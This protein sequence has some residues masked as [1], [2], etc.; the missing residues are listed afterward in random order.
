MTSDKIKK[1]REQIGAAMS[2]LDSC[3]MR[4]D[5][6]EECSSCIVH[7][8]LLSANTALVELDQFRDALALAY[9]LRDEFCRHSNPDDEVNPREWDSALGWWAELLEEDK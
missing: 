2:L 4:A 5:Q 6:P 1:I 8:V 7:D 3:A 9:L